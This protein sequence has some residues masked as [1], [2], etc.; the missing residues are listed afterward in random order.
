MVIEFLQERHVSLIEW[1]AR[2]PDLNPIEHV[3]D[4]LG[5]RVQAESPTNLRH[6]A[7]IIQIEWNLIPQ[8]FINKLV[9]SMPSRVTAVIEANGGTTRF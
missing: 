4:Y 9:G 3:W 6:L 5:R 2:S 7:E 8:E 1:P